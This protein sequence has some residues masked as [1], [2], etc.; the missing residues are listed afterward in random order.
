MSYRLMTNFKI[1]LAGSVP[2][3]FNPTRICDWDHPAGAAGLGA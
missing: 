3:P 2:N 1:V